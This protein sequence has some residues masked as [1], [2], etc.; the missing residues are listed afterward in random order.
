MFNIGSEKIPK[1]GNENISN[2][3]E[4]NKYKKNIKK[5]EKKEKER[6]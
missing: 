1:K 5:N 6:L 2:E 4:W 3:G